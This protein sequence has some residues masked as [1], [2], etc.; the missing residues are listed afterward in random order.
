MQA[1]CTEPCKWKCYGSLETST[2]HFKIKTLNLP[3]T[4]SLAVRN[5]QL[6]ST[7]IARQYLNVFRYRPEITFKELAADIMLRYNC[8]VT[9][10]KLYNARD[11]AIH[12]LR[13]TVAEHYAKLRSYMLELMRMD[14]EGRFELN[15]DVGAVFKGV[16][17]GFSS[18]RK[19]FKEGCR[20][21]IGL[22]GAFLKTYLGGV[23]LCAVATDAN[24]QMYPIAWAVCEVENI[25]NWSW[26]IRIL[27][28]DLGLGTGAGTT[29]ISDQH[30]VYVLC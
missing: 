22:D 21:V 5:K 17:I 10:W 14:K 19:G 24:K 23:L 29:F 13:G 26:F 4:C 7:W 16:Y 3:H 28:E 20:R 18:L 25:E 2:G 8:H 9:R 6:T 30:K 1:R 12:M 11:K 15:L 27:V